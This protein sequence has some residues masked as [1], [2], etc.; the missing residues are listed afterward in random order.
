[1][2]LEQKVNMK[3]LRLELKLEDKLA[4]NLRLCWNLMRCPEWANS[5]HQ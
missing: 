3:S 4:E 2:F 1:M 5:G